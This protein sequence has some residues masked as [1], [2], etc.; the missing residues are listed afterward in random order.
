LVLDFVRT[1]DSGTSG[2]SGSAGSSGSSG[3]AGTSGS[4]GSSGSGGTSGSAGTA[5]SGG[6]SGTSG[7]GGSSGTAGSGGSS[8]TRGTAGSG[9]TSGTSGSGG[10]SGTSGSGGTAGTSGSGGSSGLLAL[11]G[12][13]DNG[14]ITL[15]GSAPNGTVESNLTFDGTLLTVTGNATITGN[16]T[17]SG[18]TTTINTETINLA[19]NIITLNSNFTS[20]APTENAG[21]EVRRGSSATVS[22]YWDESNDRWTADNTLYV[23]GNVVLTGTIDTGQG[24]TEVYLMN[25]NLRTTDNVTFNQVTANTFVGSLSGN[26]TTATTATFIN[27]QDTRATASTPQ[28]QNANQG[29]R[30]DFKQNSTNG[31][32]DGGTYKQQLLDIIIHQTMVL[33]LQSEVRIITLM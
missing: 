28:T 6:S 7:S 18:T 21:I 24:A 13:T 14:V 11:T 31:L 32:N 30:F 5:G 27:V 26:A 10:T 19:D 3:S 33:I 2:T 12:T 1:G 16:L 29:V 20:G 15:N 8:G 22:F 4:A 9:G 25:Q 23:N 17:V